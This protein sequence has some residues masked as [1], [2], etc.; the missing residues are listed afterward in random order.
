MMMSVNMKLKLKEIFEETAKKEVEIR[1][2]F[3]K[4]KTQIYNKYNVEEIEKMQDE[5]YKIE[6]EENK[7]VDKLYEDAKQEILKINEKME[8]DLFA[9]QDAH[10]Y[11]STNY[12]SFYYCYD[13][14][15]IHDLENKKTYIVFV[16]FK[17]LNYEHYRRYEFEDIEIEEKELID[18]ENTPFTSK[19]IENIPF[20]YIRDTWAHSIKQLIEKI[21][22]AEVE[23]K[24]Q[25]TL[26]EVKAIVKSSLWIYDY[27]HF[28]DA[29]IKTCKQFNIQI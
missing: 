8:V 14:H 1:N 21:A 11:F 17:E 6:V 16:D 28:Y 27:S 22:K 26:Q 2:Q 3:E 18:E 4:K 5:L 7:E 9:D 12:R 29:L 13:E 20:C 24:L 15:V 19:L 23:N 10:C 25:E